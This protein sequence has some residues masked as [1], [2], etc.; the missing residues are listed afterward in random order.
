MEREI[1]VVGA[2]PSGATVAMALA[3]MGHD[4]LLLDRQS[5]PRDKTCGDAVPSGAIQVLNSLGMA[6]KIHEA[7]FY[8][9]TK[10]LLS[11]PR[12]YILEAD[13]KPGFNGANS[14]IVPRLCFD[15]LLKEHAVASG[16][17]FCQAQV[18]EPIVEDD[19]VTGV[20][21]RMN[22]LVQ[23]ISARL[24]IGADGVTSVIARALRPDKHQDVHRAVALRAYVDDIEEIPYEVEFYLYKEIL[25]GYAWIFPLGEGQANVGL[26]MRLD[27]F[28]QSGQS[29]E[30]LLALFLEMPLIKKRLKHGGRLHDIATWQ[31]NFGSQKQLQLA[32]DGALLIGDAA[33]L[34]N[35]LTGG[36]IHNGV[37][38]AHLAAEV[39]HE[40]LAKG[41]TSL[42]QLKSYQQRCEEIMS[43]GMQ[44]SYLL[45]RS[46]I[47][48]PWLTDI[49]V[50]WGKANGH[51]AQTFIDK[52]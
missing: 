24:V 43:Q 33:S 27:K 2:G 48:F 7:N 51:L 16:A 17:E 23:E 39:A 37:I 8:P 9:V 28:R 13:L 35:P 45:Q 5:F 14:Y 36:G 15:A 12:G 26:G 11:S 49:L 25:P 52:L 50:G 4:V 21:A 34:I 6:G 47:Y 46:L 30:E 32:Y 1:I 38:S 20:R 31:L 40:A 10:L 42:D 19:R 44:R 18:K 3:Q 29:L 22:G 41:D